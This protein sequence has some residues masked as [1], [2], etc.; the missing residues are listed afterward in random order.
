MELFCKIKTSDRSFIM[1]S[2]LKYISNKRINS[3][4]DNPR[5]AY[6]AL[7]Y[8]QKAKYLLGQSIMIH[9]LDRLTGVE[10]D[11]LLNAYRYMVRGMVR[12]LIS[13][14]QK[15]HDDLGQDLMFSGE[16]CDIL[17]R[18][19]AGDPNATLLHKI[20][21]EHIVETC[22][23]ETEVAE[24]EM[25]FPIVPNFTIPYLRFINL[26]AGRKANDNS[27]FREDARYTYEAAAVFPQIH[28]EDS[29]VSVCYQWKNKEPMI[30]E[31]DPD[32]LNEQEFASFGILQWI[33]CFHWNGRTLSEVLGT[34]AAMC[35]TRDNLSVQTPSSQ[36]L[37][38]LYCRVF[39]WKPAFGA[40]IE[41]KEFIASALKAFVLKLYQRDRINITERW[42]LAK[43]LNCKSEQERKLSE[44][45]SAADATVVST[46]AYQ[47][48]K[49]SEFGKIQDIDIA[50]T[51]AAAGEDDQET[52]EEGATDPEGDNP[53]E[54]PEAGDGNETDQPS[55]DPATEDPDAPPE[56][57]EEQPEEGDLEPPAEDE[58]LDPET[59]EEAPPEEGEDASTTD[60]HTPPLPPPVT[61]N[62]RGIKIAFSK[63]SEETTD[64]LMCRFEMESFIDSV[65]ANPPSNMTPQRVQL[66]VMVKRYLLHLLHL[67]TLRDIV[68][69]A[70][71]L[72]VVFKN[73]NSLELPEQ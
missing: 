41:L 20:N 59:T 50:F 23:S 52:P 53:P 4:D 38:A 66:L 31:I 24:Q 9:Y 26:L 61:N 12:E 37:Y 65:L 14:G 49:H 43:I 1:V 25:P 63:L 30:F 62:K 45:F 36:L 21:V 55:D 47:A 34:L 33:G 72:P 54:T 67:S 69:I 46:E 32:I 71:K 17:L 28:L 44:Y 60:T 5:R 57:G 8:P 15:L 22:F 70:T 35:Y 11:P 58:P 29:Y 18:P 56:E 40:E 64:S 39:G 48:F 19:N 68:A 42:L 2:Y 3:W 27:L 51:N 73:I 7:P 16:N 10:A 13:Y 6:D